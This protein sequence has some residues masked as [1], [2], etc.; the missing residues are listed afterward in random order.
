MTAAST[1]GAPL[2]LEPRDAAAWSR[3]GRVM[4]GITGEIADKGFVVAQY[5]Q[6]GELGAH[7]QPVADDLRAGLLRASR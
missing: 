4:R 2:A 6:A 3:P 5:R 1:E 7:R